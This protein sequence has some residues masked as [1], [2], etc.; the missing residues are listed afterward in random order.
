MKLLMKL[1]KNIKLGV[2]L[3]V[4]LVLLL[5]VLIIRNDSEEKENGVGVTNADPI[6]VE[7]IK[8]NVNIPLGNNINIIEVSSYMGSYVEDGSDEYIEN[9]MS[10][11]VENAG[12]D[13]IQLA[14]IILNDEYVFE[15][16]TLRPGDRMIVLEKNRSEM[17]RD[18]VITS[19]DIKNVAFFSEKPDLHKE[20]LDIK[21]V[22]QGLVINN[23]SDK[24]FPGGKVFYKNKVDATFLGGITYTVTIPELEKGEE[25][26][27]GVK[28]FNQD[29]SELI[30]VTYAE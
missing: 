23:I 7:D 13:Y 2:L 3:L 11:I 14:H 18:M 21:E 19:T 26:Q 25:V 16:T 24:T 1:R 12:D 6:E 8:E 22:D 15:L 10:I 28:H 9:V 27:L 30:F 4:F 17:E 5:I 20:L 29:S